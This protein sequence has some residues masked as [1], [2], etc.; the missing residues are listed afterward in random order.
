MSQSPNG[1]KSRNLSAHEQ[2]CE[3]GETAIPKLYLESVHEVNGKT[4]L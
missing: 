3:L 2:C 1:Q 4:R